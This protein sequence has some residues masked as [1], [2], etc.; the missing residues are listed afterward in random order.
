MKIKRDA[1]ALSSLI[2][3]VCAYDSIPAQAHRAN[4]E[5]RAFGPDPAPMNVR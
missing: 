4:G 3:D 5:A 2:I 1:P